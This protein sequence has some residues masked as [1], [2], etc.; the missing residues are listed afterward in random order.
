MRRSAAICPSFACATKTRPSGPRS[1]TWSPIPERGSATGSPRR[2]PRDERRATPVRGVARA[3]AHPAGPRGQRPWRRCRLVSPR[4]GRDAYPG[5]Q[6]RDGGPAV[7]AYPRARPGVRSGSPD[8]LEPGQH[9]APGGREVGPQGVSR[10]DRSGTAACPHDQDASRRACRA[11]H[12]RDLRPRA[13]T[14]RRWRPAP[15]PDVPQPHGGNSRADRSA[16]VPRRVHGRRPLRLSRGTAQGSAGRG[17]ARRQ[18]FSPL[19]PCWRARV[20]AHRGVARQYL[21]IVRKALAGG[22]ERVDRTSTGT[23]AVF[24]E[25]M[26]FDLSQGFLAVTTKRLAFRAV[27]AELLWFLAGSSDVND[28][29][30]LGVHIWDGNA[31]ADYWQARARF[32]GDAGRNYGQ[33]WRDWIAPDGRH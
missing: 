12:R 26:R 16:A 30:A 8:E 13:Q 32:A 10:C 31:F 25:M 33:Q 17:A 15:S 11:L 7:R 24:G 3:H 5:A 6:W 28:L 29:H 1:D 23:R 27:V 18:R 22:D 21:D 20:Q 14:R 4:G 19:A 9:P 2:W